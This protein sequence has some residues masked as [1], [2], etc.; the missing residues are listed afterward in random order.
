MFNSHQL[1]PGNMSLTMFGRVVFLLY[2]PAICFSF[3]LFPNDGH[4]AQRRQNS[5]E[6]IVNVTS[7]AVGVENVCYAQLDPCLENLSPLHAT[8]GLEGLVVDGRLAVPCES[9]IREE[10]WNCIDSLSHCRDNGLYKAIRSSQMS[11]DFICQN[12]QAFVAG[13]DCWIS[14]EFHPTFLKCLGRSNNV[15]VPTCLQKAVAKMPDC[16]TED[17]ILLG[18][19]AGISLPGDHASC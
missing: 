10:S 13:K 14:S 17:A 8:G 18:L 2:L 1:F 15:C 4:E 16:S 7:V 9:N 11:W 3:A 5:E 12:S 19:L 6:N